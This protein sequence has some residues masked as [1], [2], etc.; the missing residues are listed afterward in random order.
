MLRRLQG[1]DGWKFLA[2]LA[3]A[4]RALAWAW[5][6]WSV[7]LLRGLLPA[8]FAIVMGVLVGAAQRGSQARRWA[9]A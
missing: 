5:A 2:V 1:S 9:P 4:D 8:V 7:L 3:Q 6:W